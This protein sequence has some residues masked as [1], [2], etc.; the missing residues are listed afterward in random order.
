MKS[1]NVVSSML[2]YHV[3]LMKY[4]WKTVFE[5]VSEK[6]FLEDH[7]F[8]WGSLRNEL[9]HVASVDNRWLSGLTGGSIPD[10]VDFAGYPD[11][12]SARAFA[13]SVMERQMELLQLVSDDF[14]SIEQPGLPGAYWQI[15]MQMVNH[16]TDHR[17][18]ALV[19]LKKLGKE[20]FDQDYIFY[21]MDKIQ[22]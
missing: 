9:V 13:D 17:G 15:I 20:I 19:M 21:V 10:H 5:T 22:V 1:K 11:I 2:S 14:L 16:G 18:R 6:E 4:L 3:T 7:G 12:P 8:S